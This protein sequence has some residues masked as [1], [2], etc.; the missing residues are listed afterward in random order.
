VLPLLLLSAWVKG[1]E[2]RKPQIDFGLTILHNNDSE[3]LIEAGPGLQD[4]GGVARFA[5]LANQGYKTVRDSKTQKWKKS[6]KHND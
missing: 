6:R 2:K 3:Q 5:T 1:A 4:F